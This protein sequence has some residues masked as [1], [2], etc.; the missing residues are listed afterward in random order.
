MTIYCDICE[1][2]IIHGNRLPILNHILTQSGMQHF[3][4]HDITHLNF[5]AVRVQ[6]FSRLEIHIKNENGD[7]FPF[8]EDK[9]WCTLQFRKVK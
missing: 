1:D 9:F 2:S 4:Q 5:V 7:Y 6:E 3:V 8:K